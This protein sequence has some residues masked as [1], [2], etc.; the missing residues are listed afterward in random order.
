VIFSD[1]DDQGNFVTPDVNIVALD[2]CEI[3]GGKVVVS[4]EGDPHTYI[5]VVV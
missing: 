1:I 4:A 5:P 3:S 2:T